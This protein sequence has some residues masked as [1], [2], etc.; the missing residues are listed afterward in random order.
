MKDIESRKGEL[1][2]HNQ[3]KQTTKLPYPGFFSLL[4]IFGF[5]IGQS[6]LEMRVVCAPSLMR[7]RATPNEINLVLFYLFFSSL[8]LRK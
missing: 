2:I 7:F 6:R 3:T 4:M 1:L 8:K 5:S